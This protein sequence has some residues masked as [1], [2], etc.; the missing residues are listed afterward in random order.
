MKIVYLH[1]DKGIFTGEYA[2][3][4]S[5]LEAGVFIEPESSTDIAPPTLAANEAAVFTGGAW[6]I[7]PDFRGATWFDQVT[8]EP[9][10]ITEAGQPAANLG[11][12]LPPPTLEQAQAN[13]VNTLR[14]A[15]QQAI[16]AN[17]KY[18]SVGGIAASY[19]ADAQSVANLQASIA[20][21]MAAQ[22]TP[23][24]F[25]W[26]SA[27]NTEVPFTFADLGG[28]AAAIFAQGA[29]EFVRFQIY[30]KAVRSAATV[31]DVQSVTW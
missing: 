1:D 8:G 4:E 21:C 6:S 29:A 2:A 28:L 20:G 22:A 24:G 17:V 9:V 13:Q 26:V 15:Y 25:F 16:Q 5:P 31:A 14:A 3:Q 30:K 7:V 10:E 27:D 23:T 19:Q 12:S 11:A 18:T